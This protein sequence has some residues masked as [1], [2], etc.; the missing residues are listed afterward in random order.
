M[1]KYS[2]W[3][4]LVAALAVGMVALTAVQATRWLSQRNRDAVL[5]GTRV[6]S[7]AALPVEAPPEPMSKEE[8]LMRAIEWF[9]RENQSAQ[10]V[11][12][13]EDVSPAAD[14]LSEQAVLARFEEQRHI[15]TL[16]EL[17]SQDDALEAG[18][19]RLVHGVTEEHQGFYRLAY[20]SSKGK[21]AEF[22][23]DAN[24]GTVIHAEFSVS[25][26]IARDVAIE[27]ASL[28]KIENGRETQWHKYEALQRET[29]RYANGGPYHMSIVIDKPTDRQNGFT[30]RVTLRPGTGEKE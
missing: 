29:M 26:F 13:C 5:N 16:P 10:F 20:F 22:V 8:Q 4:Y 3:R 11:N 27:F 28:L 19:Y 6:V 1:R 12:V 23:L 24:T 30:C 17:K 25:G 21:P 9:A 7:V 15:F 14:E 18:Y 2:L